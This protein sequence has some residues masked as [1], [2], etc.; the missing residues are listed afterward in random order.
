MNE[1]KIK[2]KR[3]SIK[4]FEKIKYFKEIF[5]ELKKASEFIENKHY[6]IKLKYISKTKIKN[7]L[8][9]YEKESIIVKKNRFNYQKYI[10]I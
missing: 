9:K 8:M 2:I 6:K 1:I 5:E 10:I 3:H 7:C 4:Q